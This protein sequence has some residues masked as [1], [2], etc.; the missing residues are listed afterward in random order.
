MKSIW[1]DMVVPQISL[2][3]PGYQVAFSYRPAWPEAEVG[4]DFYNLIELGEQRFGLVLGDV[5]GKGLQA[6]VLA[7]RLQPAL[8]ALLLRPGATPAGALNDLQL[9]WMA[10]AQDRIVTLFLAC[11]DASKGTLTYCCAGHEPPL[12][13]RGGRLGRLEQGFPALLPMSVEPYADRQVQLDPGDLL[14]VFSDGLTEAG[15]R[16]FGGPQGEAGVERLLR[17]ESHQP[18]EVLLRSA[19]QAAGLRAGGHLHDDIAM[20]ALRRSHSIEESTL[21]SR[22]CRECSSTCGCCGHHSQQVALEAIQKAAIDD[23]RQVAREPRPQASKQE[24]AWFLKQ[25]STQFVRW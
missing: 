18:P 12:V 10:I 5:G 15:T 4:G 3:I 22:R 14:F 1:E 21:H 13:W 9:F 25:P 24:S 2:P 7:A 23:P 8:M 19:C 16:S 11:L 20:L 17:Q 6:A